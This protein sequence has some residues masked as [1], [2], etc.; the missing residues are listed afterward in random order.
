MFCEKCGHR[1]EPTDAACRNCGTPLGNGQAQSS[2]GGAFANSYIGVRRSGVVVILLSIV[3]CGIYMFYWLYQ[4][5]EDI[6]RTSGHQRINSVAFLIGSLVCTPVL[7]IAL[8]KIDQ[9]MVRLSAE[10]GTYYREN[11][12]LWLILTIFVGFGTFVAAYQICNA[13][14][15]I[16][17]RR[18]GIAPP[19]YG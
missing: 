1:V 13:Y 3:T 2:S 9:E 11:F 17:D 4:A 12:I 18:Q 10:N 16:W 5:M 8:Y 14:N 7:L 15:N 19:M 6:N